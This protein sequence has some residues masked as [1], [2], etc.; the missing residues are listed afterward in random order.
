[1]DTCDPCVQ[2]H[3]PPYL[4]EA[5]LVQPVDEAASTARV[6]DACV[7]ISLAKKTSGLWKDLLSA[8]GLLI[9]EPH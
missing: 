8:A 4:F 1:M 6:T 5:F 3:H 9:A 7:F 2:V